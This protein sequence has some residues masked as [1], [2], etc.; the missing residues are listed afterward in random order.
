MTLCLFWALM[1]RLSVWS[2]N[3]MHVLAVPHCDWLNMQKTGTPE[4]WSQL[5][6]CFLIKVEILRA[7]EFQNKT[8]YF[9]EIRI[10][11][12]KCFHATL[13]WNSP[14]AAAAI[15]SAPHRTPPPPPCRCIQLL[16]S[17]ASKRPNN[18]AV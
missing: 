2:T 3:Q 12:H 18:A 16:H 6:S 17:M 11:L 9:V 7:S 14:Q 4:N 13:G 5:K 10:K 1:H 15:A 8:F